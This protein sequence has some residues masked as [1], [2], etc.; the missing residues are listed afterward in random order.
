MDELR[1][2]LFA[3]DDGDGGELSMING[4]GKSASMASNSST[5]LPFEFEFPLRLVLLWPLLDDV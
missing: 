5:S 2:F 1:R 4:Y 3:N